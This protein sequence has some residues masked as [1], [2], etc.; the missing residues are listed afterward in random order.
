MMVSIHTGECWQPRGPI[1][2]WGLLTIGKFRYEVMRT[3]ESQAYE[4]CAS[5]LTRH[6]RDNILHGGSP[7][8]TSSV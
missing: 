4:A 7:R 6:G 8:S 2:W 3:S 5:Y 1:L